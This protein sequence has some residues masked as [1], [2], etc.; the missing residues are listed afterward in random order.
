MNNP[1]KTADPATLPNCQNTTA[2][3]GQ[4]VAIA[5]NDTKARNTVPCNADGQPANGT[6]VIGNYTPAGKDYIANCTYYSN[7]GI[8]C[9]VQP[10]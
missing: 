10:I 6:Y 5:V 2:P 4:T 3:D 1:G 8:L 9:K 7:E